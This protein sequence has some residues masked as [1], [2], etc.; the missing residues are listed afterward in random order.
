[1]HICFCYQAAEI[2]LVLSLAPRLQVMSNPT[3]GMIFRPAPKK[4]VKYHMLADRPT[5]RIEF[6]KGGGD[7]FIARM[8]DSPLRPVPEARF[9]ALPQPSLRSPDLQICVCAV[10]TKLEHCWR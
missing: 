4:P 9:Q 7:I 3:G 8:V 10:P 1:M 2:S 6:S 5:T